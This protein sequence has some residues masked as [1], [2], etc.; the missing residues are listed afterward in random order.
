MLISLSLKVLLLHVIELAVEDQG[1]GVVRL[2]VLH[3][4]VRV[5]WEPWGWV[6]TMMIRGWV[7]KTRSLLFL[8]DRTSFIVD[9][10]VE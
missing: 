3:L 8:S 4:L 10:F 9:D 2:E 6:V 7:V 5:E 1:S